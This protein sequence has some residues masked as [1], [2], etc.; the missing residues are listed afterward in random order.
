[1]G[2]ESQRQTSLCKTSLWR[3]PPFRSR[4]RASLKLGGH[5]ELLNWSVVPMGNSGGLREERWS[6]HKMSATPLLSFARFGIP[7]C[8]NLFLNLS[9]VNVLIRYGRAPYWRSRKSHI[10]SQG[11]CLSEDGTRG[12][13]QR[14]GKTQRHLPERQILPTQSSARLRARIK[15]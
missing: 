3:L 15:S 9:G 2:Y 4:S 5:V 12:G 8:D 10:D 1:V 7:H 14:G 6:A 13:C 11:Q